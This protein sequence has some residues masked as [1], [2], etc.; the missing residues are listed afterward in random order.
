MFSQKLRFPDFNDEWTQT[1]LGE[2]AERITRKNVGNTTQ[3]VLTISA[4]Y[5]L[6]DQRDFFNK[7]VAST[8]IEGYYLLN[9]GE[10]AYNRSSST[11]YP[12]GAIKRLDNYN[13][14]V[15]STLYIC[16]A[17]LKEDTS[18]LAH[19]F[20][21]SQW[22]NYIQSISAEGARN[23]GLL[24]IA[25]SD[26]FALPL[27]LPSSL[28]EQKKIADF[29]SLIDERIEVEEQLLKKYEEQKKYLLR[30]MFV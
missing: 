19:F 28:A 2:I 9:K 10:F 20:E 26:F 21:T 17:I 11:D 6:I 7:T 25:V 15:L 22:H 30:N 8:N 4:Q 29:L 13:E 1:T 3:R 12:W 24:N 14:G 5:G 23:H 16:F 27:S 18:F